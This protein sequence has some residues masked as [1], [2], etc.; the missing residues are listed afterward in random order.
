MPIA[1]RAVSGL[2]AFAAAVP[3]CRAIGLSLDPK[4]AR[5]VGAIAAVV[6]A[7]GVALA[8]AAEEVESQ[9]RA[10]LV[11][12]GIDLAGAAALAIFATRR[13][14]RAHLVSVFVSAF[15]AFGATAWLRGAR[16]LHD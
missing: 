6:D 5:Q 8:F 15:L 4:R 2:V 14:V 16:Q 12:A 11:N 1:G 13:G 7:A 10:A 3:L 9:R